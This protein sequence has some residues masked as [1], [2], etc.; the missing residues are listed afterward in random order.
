MVAAVG[1]A[2]AAPELTLSN[3]R[4]TRGVLGPTRDGSRVLPG[5]SLFVCFDVE[6]VTLADDGK[7][8]YSTAMEVTDASGRT[9]FK[10]D[11][12][13]QQAVCSLG[14]NRLPAFVRLHVGPDQPPG[15]YTLQATVTDRTSSSKGTLKRTFEVLPAGF[16]IVQLSTTADHGGMLPMPVPAAGQGLWLH[17]GVVGFGRDDA[18]HQP[19]V[20]IALRVLDEDGKPTLAQPASGAVGKGVPEKD[21]VLPMQLALLLNRP[22]KFTVE[23]TAT[24]RV[25]GK[26]DTVTFPLTVAANP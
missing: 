16:G 26:K 14:G 5:D 21:V 15:Q 19:N 12:R 22:G 13:D 1:T 23:L 24:D 20:G 18:G 6:G 10:Q 4:F 8:V 2:P 17:F 11:P 7:V 9:V 25:S 3:V